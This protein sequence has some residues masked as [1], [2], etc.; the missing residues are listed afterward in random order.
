MDFSEA[1]EPVDEPFRGKIRRG[2]DGEHAAA[3]ALQQALGSVADA[4]ES[5][6]H[7][8]EISTSRLGDHEPLS[9]A[10]EKL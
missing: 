3:L 4:V 7:H 1:A 9:L 6:A 5:V 8:D 2:A 10:V